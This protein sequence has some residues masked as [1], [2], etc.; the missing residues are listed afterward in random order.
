MK[1]AILFLAIAILSMATSGCKTRTATDL[2]KTDDSLEPVNYSST[3]SGDDNLGRLGNGGESEVYDP[4]RGDS[5]EGAEHIDQGMERLE[6]PGWVQNELVEDQLIRFGY[7]E[8]TVP[9]YEK[10][11]LDAMAVYLNQN[12]KY[13]LLIEGHCDERGSEDYNLSLGEQRALATRT[14][15]IERGVQSQRL[16]TISYGEEMPRQI[17]HNEVAW[18]ENRRAELRLMV[19]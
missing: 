7:D 10:P 9:D 1:Q 13:H 14:G 18:R 3:E 11:K 15:L 12:P 8:R 5:F 6:D 4:G 17:G 16:T 19:P 2:A